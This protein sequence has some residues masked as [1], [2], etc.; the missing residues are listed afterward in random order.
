MCLKAGIKSAEYLVMLPCIAFQC[1]VVAMKCKRQATFSS[2]SV[3]DGK[4]GRIQLH[5]QRLFIY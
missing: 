2:T 1:V 5:L 3:V 4:M